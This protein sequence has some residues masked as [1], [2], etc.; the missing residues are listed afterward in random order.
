MK[1]LYLYKEPQEDPDLA[2]LQAA[3]RN[4]GHEVLEEPLYPA[5]D[6]E[7]LLAKVVDADQV[8]TWK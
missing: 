8:I 2:Q 7:T 1:I 3:Q 5:P 6:Y 4:L